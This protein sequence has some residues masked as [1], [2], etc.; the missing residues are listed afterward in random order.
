[1]SASKGEDV[2]YH[3]V[4]ILVDRGLRFDWDVEVETAES[5]RQRL[6]DIV[7]AGALRACGALERPGM[8]WMLP[9][10][11]VNVAAAL[12]LH[13][14]GLKTE[15]DVAEWSAQ[16]AFV[17]VADLVAEYAARVIMGLPY[18]NEWRMSPENVKADVQL[19]RQFPRGAARWPFCRL[20]SEH[21]KARYVVPRLVITA[22]PGG[23]LVVEGCD[24]PVETTLM[25]PVQ[26]VA[27]GEVGIALREVPSGL[28][29]AEF[30]DDADRVL[31]QS[32]T[33][34]SPLHGSDAA[35]AEA[36]SH[37]VGDALRLA[38]MERWRMEHEGEV[39]APFKP[40]AG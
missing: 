22:C 23:H 38:N 39:P 29:V 26:N 9:G 2:T 35:A 6:A 28:A 4:R 21:A 12:F 18:T 19:L 17:D 36:M 40:W 7:D 24:R 37:P 8:R 13:A 16:R 5:G 15:A 11:H 1:M 20:L 31:V 33:G 14:W 3:G 25:T 30:R 27:S 32:V 34:P 10:E